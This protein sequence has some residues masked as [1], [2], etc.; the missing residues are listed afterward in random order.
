MKNIDLKC[1]NGETALFDASHEGN[2][3]VVEVLI[4]KGADIDLQNKDGKYLARRR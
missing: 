4:A 1:N 3:E 2:R